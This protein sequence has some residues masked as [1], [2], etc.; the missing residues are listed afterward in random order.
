MSF[1]EL[2]M[3]VMGMWERKWDTTL[4]KSHLDSQLRMTKGRGRRGIDSLQKSGMSLAENVAINVEEHST[5][6]SI[7]PKPSIQNH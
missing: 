6:S 1:L 4:I 3:V 7:K 2:V 5:L